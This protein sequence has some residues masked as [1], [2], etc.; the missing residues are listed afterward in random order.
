MS[1]LPTGAEG[2]RNEAWRRTV[3]WRFGWIE[4]VILAGAS[5]AAG[6]IGVVAGL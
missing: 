3:T 1:I 4:L 6:F 2:E 5:V